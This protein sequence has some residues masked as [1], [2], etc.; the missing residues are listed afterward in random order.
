LHHAHYRKL[1]TER[2]QTIRWKETG[3]VAETVTRFSTRREALDQRERSALVMVC[4]ASVVGRLF[5]KY[6]TPGSGSFAMRKCGYRPV[7]IGTVKARINRSSAPERARIAPGVPKPPPDVRLD[8]PS[9]Q[10]ASCSPSSESVCR[11]PSSISG[12]VNDAIA[13]HPAHPV[14]GR[15]PTT[16]V[17]TSSEFD[18]P[19]EISPAS[20]LRLPRI[21]VV[22]VCEM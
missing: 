11:R 9:L 19:L 15:L 2:R 10:H 17:Y 20:D 1:T 7:Q 16:P 21:D 8:S 13:T 18:R 6:D 3:E 12:S 5:G 14:S 22:A 4:A